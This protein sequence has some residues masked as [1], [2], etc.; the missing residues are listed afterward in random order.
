MN[1][2]FL[3]RLLSYAEGI[4]SHDTLNDTINTLEGALFAACFSEWVASL[5]EAEPDIVAIDGKTSRRTHDC[6]K[7]RRL[8]HLV[9]AWKLSSA[10]PPNAVQTIPLAAAL[11]RPVPRG[12][13][14]TPRAIRG[15]RRR[16]SAAPVWCPRRR[17][18]R[19]P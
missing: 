17:C 1:L 12:A 10:R 3:R 8:L 9:S 11:V 14:V 7:E 4:P 5:R 6:G 13:A 16:C 19:G 2:D 18:A 15:G